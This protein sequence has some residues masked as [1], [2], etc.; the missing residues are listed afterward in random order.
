VDGKV[1]LRYRIEGKVNSGIFWREISE[2]G[3]LMVYVFP[4]LKFP[5]G[6]ISE[7]HGIENVGIF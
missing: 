1:P 2:Q 7:G 5:F 3:C 4:N 6:Y